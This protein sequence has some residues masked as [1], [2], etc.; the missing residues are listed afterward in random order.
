MKVPHRELRAGR[1]GISL[2]PKGR[3]EDLP[4]V[5]PCGGLSLIVNERL[6]KGNL[7]PGMRMETPLP[8][9]RAT[10]GR[11]TETLALIRSSMISCNKL[12]NEVQRLLT[13]KPAKI[14]LIQIE[15]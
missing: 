7:A 15:K 2:Y 8:Q 4:T 3:K 13:K 6:F 10:P 12:L 1:F 14:F 11:E 9:T 5:L